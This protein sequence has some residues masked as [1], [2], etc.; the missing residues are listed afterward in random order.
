MKR[1]PIR[2]HP[3]PDRLSPEERSHVLNRERECIIPILVRLGK[4]SP[5]DKDAVCRDQWGDPIRVFTLD[6]LTYEH[7][8]PSAGMGIR[9][10]SGDWLGRRWGVAACAHHNNNGATSKYRAAIRDYLADREERGML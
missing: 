9:A 4:I 7:V 10:P 2:R 3:A 1:T 8:K 6:N 5:P